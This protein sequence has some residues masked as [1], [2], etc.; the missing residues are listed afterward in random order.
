MAEARDGPMATSAV[1]TQD[2][3]PTWLLILVLTHR[4]PTLHGILRPSG[5]K[6][7][8]TLDLCFN[9]IPIPVVALLHSQRIPTRLFLA[10]IMNTLR[11]PL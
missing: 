11:I 5:L 9:T 1:T 7:M 10:T 8:A 4:R 6:K 2:H 3:M